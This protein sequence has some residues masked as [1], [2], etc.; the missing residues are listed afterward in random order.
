M[1][2]RFF[3]TAFLSTL[4]ACSSPDTRPDFQD[5][6]S[7]GSPIHSGKPAESD[8]T[9]DTEP[10][11]ETE[12]SGHLEDT[13][14]EP[15]SPSFEDCF[16]DILSDAP[17]PDYEQYSPKIGTHC[18]GTQHQNIE[19]IQR[20]VFLGDSVT[21]GTPPTPDSENYRAVLA[22]KLAQEFNLQAP[23]W[24]WEAINLIDGTALV[25][26]SGDFASC[27]KWGARTDDL[28]EDNDQLKDCLP[29]D[30]R[31]LNTLVVLTAGD[32]AMPVSAG[33]ALARSAGLLTEEE[34]ARLVAGGVTTGLAR[35]AHDQ[36]RGRGWIF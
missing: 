19:N 28:L 4:L 21:V 8:P 9:G 27:A 1:R 22:K 3:Q 13:Q 26:E 12:D 32:T 31:H 24:S 18:K 2:N 5:T 25:Q 7:S 10:E 20:V 35:L 15:A 16:A 36:V 14:S 11:I 6:A 23:D 34:D 17:G 29:E 33:L 30:K